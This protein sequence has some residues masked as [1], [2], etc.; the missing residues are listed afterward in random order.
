[1]NRKGFTLVE[2]LV[3]IG[4][5]ALLIA[6]LLPSLNKAR[7]QAYLVTCTSNMRQCGLAMFMYA[8]DNRG[9]LPGSKG[10]GPINLDWSGRN[11]ALYLQSGG[12]TH[13][14]YTSVLLKYISTPR[15]LVCPKGSPNAFFDY[16]FVSS[17][18]GAKINLPWKVSYPTHPELE[19]P[20]ANYT[21]S[22]QEAFPTTH[23][24]TSRVFFQAIPML[25]EESDAFSQNNYNDGAFA[26][27]DQF[28][29][30]RHQGRCSIAYMDGSVGTF[31]A[32]HGP[33]PTLATLKDL[34]CY[35]LLLHAGAATYEIDWDICRYGWANDPAQSTV[36]DSN[37][38]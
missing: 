3:V 15:M 6:L 8:Q 30:G 4:I 19:N 27:W 13:P 34:R 5:I 20:W 29:T 38:P 12:N 24:F 35:N 18:T 25:I 11:N 7:E 32:P 31:A 23:D 22:Q 37:N 28:N 2:L 16:T 10:Q 36:I 9:R 26:T 21:T 1:M 14:I 17:F 33:K